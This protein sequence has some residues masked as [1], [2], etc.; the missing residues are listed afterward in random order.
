M[1]ISFVQDPVTD[2][3]LFCGATSLFTP[4]LSQLY[5]SH[6][7]LI[8]GTRRDPHLLVAVPNSWEAESHWTGVDSND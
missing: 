3:W 1:P 7:A 8:L 4:W 5:R 6:T 2:P